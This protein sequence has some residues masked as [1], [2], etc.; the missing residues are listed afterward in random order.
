MA[1]LID[2]MSRYSRL[3]GFQRSNSTFHINVTYNRCPTD[4]GGAAWC[5]VPGTPSLGGY[6]MDGEPIQTPNGVRYVTLML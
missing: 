3:T 1:K 5:Y 4:P 6:L 2:E